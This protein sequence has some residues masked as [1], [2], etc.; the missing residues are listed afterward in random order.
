MDAEQ[1]R[2][3]DYSPEYAAFVEKFKPKKTTDD[4]YTPEIVFDAVLGWV[5]EHLIGD[6]EIVRPF[7]PGGDYER[8]DYPEGSIV[9]DNPPFSIITKITRDYQRIG[10]KFFLF[11][12]HLTNFSGDT[13]G[14]THIIAGEAITYENGATVNTSFL[15]NMMPGVKAIASPDLSMVVRKADE[16]NRK[17]EKKE[18][19]KYA[20]PDNVLTVSDLAYMAKHGVSFS[21]NDSD[22]AHVRLLD[23][24]KAVGK[25]IFGS[26]YL[27]SEKAAAEKAAAEKAAAEKANAIRWALSEREWQIVQGLG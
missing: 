16:E 24:Q 10:I 27:L 25:A 6:V 23:S 12:P 17:K 4:C 13:P 19:P 1:I 22:C 18:L 26:G 5:R 15:T 2:L 7:Y 9:V 21:V 11:A 20:Y 8:F 14:V 3:S